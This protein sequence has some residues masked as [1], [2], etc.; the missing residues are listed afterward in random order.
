MG[1][2]GYFIA[3]PAER[4]RQEGELVYDEEEGEFVEG[5]E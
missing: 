1:V 4:D 3:T 2:L 5:D